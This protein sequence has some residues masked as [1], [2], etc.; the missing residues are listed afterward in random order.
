VN[1]ANARALGGMAMPAWVQLDCA[2]L[3]SAM[4][5]LA[6]PRADVDAA[7]FA[8][9]R[10]GVAAAFGEHAARDV[11]TWQGLVP[12]AEYGCVP[13]PEPGRVVGFSLFSLV[14]GL[15]V[16]TKAA[17]LLMHQARVQVGIAQVDNPALR[18]HT[19]IGPLD[20]VAARVPVHSKPHETIVYALRVPP[21]D[22][23]EGIARGARLPP[24]PQA[25]ARIALGR[26]TTMELAR[27]L[28]TDGPHAI[29]DMR[30]DA[31]LLA[32]SP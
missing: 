26:D 1:A 17:A 9:L 13:T 6:R 16:R 10:E 4:I 22:V 25:S 32:R 23:L 18:T 19:A 7:L 12:L 21:D 30:D 8:S 29:V 5:G 24:R 20:V 3:P 2:C 11:D 15:G 27:L 31:L 28:E 14:P